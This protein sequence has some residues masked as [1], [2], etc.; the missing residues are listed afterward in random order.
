M[1]ERRANIEPESSAGVVALPDVGPGHTTEPITFPNQ[2]AWQATTTWRGSAPTYQQAWAH[3]SDA[4][5]P[6][7]FT[8]LARASNHTFLR[9]LRASVVAPE[10][11]DESPSRDAPVLAARAWN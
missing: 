1:P 6:P 7:R 5:L 3:L 8:A 11:F 4:E 9:K 2:G 10:L